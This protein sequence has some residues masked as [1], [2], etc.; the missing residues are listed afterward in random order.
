MKL[1]P[2]TYVLLLG[3]WRW[4][5]VVF[6]TIVIVTRI[7]L[8]NPC[9]SWGRRSNLTNLTR[10]VNINKR[11]NVISRHQIWIEII[12][13]TVL[14]SNLPLQDIFLGYYLLPLSLAHWWIFVV[15]LKLI[16]LISLSG[17]FYKIYRY[18]QKGNVSYFF[19]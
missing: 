17:H 3:I 16:L 14:T 1:I 6:T 19:F 5:L 12:K 8:F 2:P 11:I 18:L 9:I 13:S 10:T 15:T 7:Y 4:I